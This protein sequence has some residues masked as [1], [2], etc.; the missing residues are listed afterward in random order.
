M[1]E[2]S[3]GSVTLA[4]PL[5]VVLTTTRMSPTMVGGP[6]GPEQRVT[7]HAEA[8]VLL[9]TSLMN[10]L[11][12]LTALAEAKL[13]RAN[14][15]YRVAETYADVLESLYDSTHDRGQDV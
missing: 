12:N 8:P 9:G 4:S 14:G 7:P 11:L 3:H 1:C 15:R 10:E 2:P 13:R 5:G 6:E